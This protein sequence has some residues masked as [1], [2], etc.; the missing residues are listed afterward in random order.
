MIILLTGQSHRLVNEKL[1]QIVDSFNNK[2]DNKGQV[3]R[4]SFDKDSRADEIKN[5]VGTPSLFATKQLVIIRYAIS[6]LLAAENAKLLELVKKGNIPETT[7][8]VFV[9]LEP[10]PKVTK[11]KLFGYLKKS[12]KVR[13]IEVKS[14]TGQAAIKDIME[15]TEKLGAKILPQTARL[16]LQ[17]IGQDYDQV[18]YELEKLA[19]FAATRPDKM[20]TIADIEDTIEAKLESDI[21]KTI[22]ALG[23]KDVKQAL[24][25]LH[26]HEAQGAHPLY[27]L[28]MLRYQFRTMVQ[29]D[30]AQKQTNDPRAIAQ[31]TGISPYVIRKTQ[32]QL[33]NYA[34]RDL[35]K[36]FI[37]MVDADEAI[38]T[39]RVDGELALDLLTFA[40]GV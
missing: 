29:I 11:N 1:E 20:I 6:N 3:N 23:Q 33:C 22:D 4:K 27:L 14:L 26:R 38:K 25:L 5:L 16:I 9:E 15:R 39:S 12:K 18:I 35:K 37:K 36:I 31:I 19:L 28:T 2:T 30:E 8:V 10:L 34:N 17:K 13:S 32:G 7:S 24:T 40:L 21:F